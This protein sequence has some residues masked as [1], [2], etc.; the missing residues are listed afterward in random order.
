I[1]IVVAFVRELFGKGTLLA[2]SGIT[3]NV[4]GAGPEFLI[5]TAS[6]GWSGFLFGWYANN[7]M[8][9]MSVAAMF[10]IAVFIWIQRARNPKLVDIS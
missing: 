8:M 6:D 2:G 3:L 5:N 4:I 10:I 1:L 9:V 7:N